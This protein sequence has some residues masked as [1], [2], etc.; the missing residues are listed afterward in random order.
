MFDIET[1]TSR[2]LNIAILSSITRLSPQLI[3]IVTRILLQQLFFILLYKGILPTYLL[4]LLVIITCYFFFHDFRSFSGFRFILKKTPTR[5]SK[6]K[7]IFDIPADLY[8]TI[9]KYRFTVL[10][11]FSYRI[12]P[13]CNLS[14]FITLCGITFWRDKCQKWYMHSVASN[15]SYFSN[16]CMLSTMK[17]ALR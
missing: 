11:L 4:L 10:Y 17:V 6:D 13:K 8:P 1:K 7:I 12:F 5:V 3:P 2:Y 14:S 9:C 16:I 15:E